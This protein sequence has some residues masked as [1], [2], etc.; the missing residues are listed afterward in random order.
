[1][2]TPDFCLNQS[3]IF[4]VDNKL[5]SG[6]LYEYYLDFFRASR[7]STLDSNSE[8]NKERR[9]SSKADAWTLDYFANYGYKI[10]L[11]IDRDNSGFVRISE[12][13]AF[14]DGIPNGWS[15]PQWCAYTVAGSYIVYLGP[16]LLT[17]CL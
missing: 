7:I 4:C 15:L 8:A 5:F 16:Q 9:N 17:C 11:A 1:M 12:A 10:A 14:T 3:W 13:N 6:A 2:K